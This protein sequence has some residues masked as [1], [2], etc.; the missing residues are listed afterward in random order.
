MITIGE[1]TR[2]HFAPGLTVRSRLFFMAALICMLA[3]F[4][5][6]L[7]ETSHMHREWFY[8]PTTTVISHSHN[9]L[10]VLCFGAVVSV[11]EPECTFVALLPTISFELPVSEGPDYS[12]SALLDHFIRP[13]PNTPLSA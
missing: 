1:P 12:H 4:V 13:P 11:P 7:L 6:G 9:G 8:P 3:L 5:V 10:C 2:N